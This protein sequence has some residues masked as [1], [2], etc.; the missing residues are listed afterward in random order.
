MINWRQSGVRMASSERHSGDRVV[1]CP[2]IKEGQFLRDF[3]VEKKT[4][5][6]PNVSYKSTH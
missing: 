6:E 5:S 1:A 4:V 2:K 3:M